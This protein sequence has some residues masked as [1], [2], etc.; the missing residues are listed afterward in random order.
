[1]IISHLSEEY[2]KLPIEHNNGAFY[3]SKDL[4]ENIIP[5]IKTDRNWIC[6]N[7]ENT[8]LD[9]SI[10]FIHNN[11]N[12]ERYTWLAEYKDL[13]L[14]CSSIKTLQTMIEMFPKFHCIFIP[15]SIDTAYVEKFRV[16]RKTK[17][18]AYFGRME[19]I[20]ESIAKD[21]T[22]DKITGL[23]RD[24]LLRTVAKY[25]T[26]YAIGRCAVEA[27]CLGCEVISHEGEFEN[28]SWDVIDNKEIIPELQRIL[29]DID[30]IIKKRNKQ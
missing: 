1:M 22:I 29:D 11:K 20:P 24:E 18:I 6:I 15:L 27:K 30:G 12:P 8:C 26:V 21:E 23:D 9:H 28:K 14:V 17:K 3:Y 25:K 2:K 10:V 7:A 13:I 5:F 4:V 16:K 19:K